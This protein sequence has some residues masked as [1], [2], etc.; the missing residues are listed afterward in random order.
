MLKYIRE[1]FIM[2]KQMRLDIKTFLSEKARETFMKIYKLA[3]CVWIVFAITCILNKLIGK[4]HPFND[5]LFTINVVIASIGAVCI[6]FHII[7]YFYYVRRG[8]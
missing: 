1:D 2:T 6:L 5:T 7:R 8:K 4:D 3:V